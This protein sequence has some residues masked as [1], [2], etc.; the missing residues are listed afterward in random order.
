MRFGIWFFKT[1]V[2]IVITYKLWLKHVLKEWKHYVLSA[3]QIVLIIKLAKP[4]HQIA[5]NKY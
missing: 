1:E 3:K 4:T 2:T 5:G